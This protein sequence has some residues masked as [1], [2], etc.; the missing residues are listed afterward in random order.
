MWKLVAPIIAFLP[1]IAAVAQSSDP[2]KTYADSM[3]RVIVAA[4]RDGLYANFAPAM[5]RVYSRDDLL[6]P[7]EKSKDI[8]GSISH[9]EYR[10]ATVGK[11]TAGLTIIRIATCWYAVETTNYP[12]SVFV[13]VDVTFDEGRYFVAGYRIERFTNGIPPEL[14]RPQG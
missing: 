7:L 8:F 4:D 2:A 13:D 3:V 9:P 14:R 10:A 1:S 12:L 6:G 11:R 5:K